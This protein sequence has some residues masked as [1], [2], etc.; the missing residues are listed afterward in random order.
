MNETTNEKLILNCSFLT[1]K[2]TWIF[3]KHTSNCKLYVEEPQQ[4]LIAYDKPL[5]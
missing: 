4:K 2:V 3:E 5:N 1:Q